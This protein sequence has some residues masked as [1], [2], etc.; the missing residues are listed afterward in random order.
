MLPDQNPNSSNPIS[1]SPNIHS[2][3]IGSL[4]F[5]VGCWIGY[6]FYNGVGYLDKSGSAVAAG[7]LLHPIFPIILLVFLWSILPYV[8]P[9]RIIGFEI[10][11]VSLWLFLRLVDVLMPFI[12][13]FGLAYFFHFVVGELQEI[14]LPMGRKL[15]ISR[16]VA[17]FF[18]LALTLVF[19]FL[20]FGLV[21][22]QIS[23]QVV[24]MSK[25]IVVF[26][27]ESLMPFV[28][29]TEDSKGALQRLEN[30]GQESNL[31]L[32]RDLT[33]FVKNEGQKM[34]TK[35]Q[36][37]LS[38]NF[39]SIA[40][41][42]GGLF[43]RIFKGMSALA[44]G[45]GGF[46][47]TVFLALIVF[48]Y[49][50]HSL[51]AYVQKFVNLFPVTQRDSV[52]LYLQEI[53]DNMESFLRGQVIVITLVSSLSMAIYSIIGVPFALIVGALAGLCNAVPTF[54]PFIGG[55]FALVALLIG[56]ATGD[57]SMIGLLFRILA[58]LGAIVGIQTID[59]S[60]ISPKIMS[61]AIDIDPLTIMFS[62]IIGATLLGLWGAILAIPVLVIIKSII[63]VKQKLMIFPTNDQ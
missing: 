22:P 49:A 2:T 3:V 10:V 61:N 36:S 24:A 40:E 25:G 62:V 21:T 45:F 37:Y 11:F 59:N 13:G 9:A 5:L 1:P 41:S 20:L 42:G 63:N 60:I 4:V 55:I 31:Q 57:F 23:Q 32:I 27:Q 19:L 28:L 50:S 29:G 6:A 30:W 54:G 38:T 52:W 15:H 39:G 12:L 14:R 35:V 18:L 16:P 51:K 7:L 43:N 53:H 44:I 58:I 56:F 33:Y 26:Y 34:I 47:T 48:I 46:L 17:S 8:Q